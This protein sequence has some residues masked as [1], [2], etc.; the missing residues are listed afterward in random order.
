MENFKKVLFAAAVVIM[1]AMMSVSCSKKDK[2]PNYYSYDGKKFGIKWA[3]YYYQSGDKGYCFGISS[4][5]P[6]GRLFNELNFFEVDYPES[7]LGTKCD[8]SQDNISTNGW[9][10]YGFLRCDGSIL[11]YFDD[12]GTTDLHDLSGTNNWV[13]VTKNSVNNFTL[14]FSMTINGKLL[15]GYY[16][17]NFQERTNYWDISPD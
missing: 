15:K 13:K 10:L 16:K 11:Y 6:T 17:G 5:V 4:T 3:G 12:A 2:N 1:A 8:L 14:E 7:K 9:R